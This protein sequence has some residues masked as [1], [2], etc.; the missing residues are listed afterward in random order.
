MNPTD[1]SQMTDMQL[2][3]HIVA[4]P[5]NQEALTIYVERRAQRAFPVIANVKDDDFDA[6][7]QSAI[8]Q[9]LSKTATT[10]F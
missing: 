7:L 4:H 8:I 10:E 5:E 2:K 3:Q 6:K 1:Y 9:K